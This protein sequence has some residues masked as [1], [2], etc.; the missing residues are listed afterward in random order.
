MSRART[1]RGA[2][3]SRPLS[4]R[5]SG[6]KRSGSRGE[7][8][9]RVAVGNER[10]GGRLA[11]DLELRVEA[12]APRDQRARNG[13]REGAVGRTLSVRS[14]QVVDAAH[15]LGREPDRRGEAEA[16]AVDAAE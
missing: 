3:K 2:T 5:A 14:P 11:V 6:A 7:V 10:E 16:P 9:V 15:E 1:R 8:R 4:K 13:E 12:P